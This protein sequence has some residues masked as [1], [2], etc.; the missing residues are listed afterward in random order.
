MMNNNIQK[1]TKQN[2]LTSNNIP[3]WWKGLAKELQSDV[4]SDYG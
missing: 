2:N 1:S 4:E 3:K